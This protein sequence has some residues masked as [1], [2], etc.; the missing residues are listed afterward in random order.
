MKPKTVPHEF[1][2]FF[3][4]I[5]IGLFAVFFQ[6]L[7][8]PYALLKETEKPKGD[9]IYRIEF[10]NGGYKTVFA[11]EPLKITEILGGSPCRAEDDG[12]VS[13]NRRL[14]LRSDS[15][16]EI[17]RFKGS[18]LSAIGQKIDINSADQ[19]D[20]SM[21]PGLGPST[22][23]KIVNYRET[24]GLFKDVSE[25]KKITGIKDKK[26]S[27]YEPFLDACP[28]E[29]PVKRVRLRHE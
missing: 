22:A 5:V 11:P 29:P 13:C 27:S 25:L 2:P 9:C 15:E 28:T 20:L 16:V 8:H 14:V 10:P 24:H 23:K 26:F 12:V 3:G 6:L 19:E 7:S 1:S 21:V 17:R 18:D 4:I